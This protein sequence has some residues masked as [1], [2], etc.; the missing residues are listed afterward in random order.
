M[1][2]GL[3]PFKCL[4]VLAFSGVS[5]L[6]GDDLG[7]EVPGIRELSPRRELLFFEQ[8][9]VEAVPKLLGLAD[10]WLWD[11]ESGSITNLHEQTAA[12]LRSPKLKVLRE[13]YIAE[14][15]SLASNEL[16][17]AVSARDY[18]AIAKVALRYRF[19][20]AGDQAVLHVIRR[21]VDRGETEVAALFYRGYLRDQRANLVDSVDKRLMGEAGVRLLEQA[22]FDTEAQDPTALTRASEKLVAAWRE[23]P[24]TEFRP[25]KALSELLRL[26]LVYGVA[27]SEVDALFAQCR[28]FQPLAMIAPEFKIQIELDAFQTGNF[29]SPIQSEWIERF[30]HTVQVVTSRYAEIIIRGDSTEKYSALVRLVAFGE[31]AEPM[32]PVLIVALDDSDQKVWRL[33]LTLIGRLGERGKSASG[34]M[35]Q[36]LSDPRNEF[37][38]KSA[39]TL[40][41][42][43]NAAVPDLAKALLSEPLDQRLMIVDLLIINGRTSVT[44]LPEI[45]QALSDS[46]PIMQIAALEILSVLGEASLPALDRV[47]ALTL[48]PDVSVEVA[49]ITAIRF[50]GPKAS[51]AID[52][53]KEKLQSKSSKVRLAAV[54]ALGAMG[55]AASSAAERLTEVVA[56][57]P[58]P[59]VREQATEALVQVTAF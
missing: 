57:D 6:F 39:Y 33:A 3:I 28:E 36:G 26:A 9:D 47:S 37:R 58:S 43:G 20:P 1:K 44:A 24:A 31:T 11:K 42:M 35:I 15:R 7:L 27:S 54:E 59:E 18:T 53:L 4:V 41:G 8:H 55:K 14:F 38:L 2:T 40:Q 52:P 19:T 17:D 23:T 45:I 25:S 13:N 48:D 29:T 32:L 21:S 56:E 10:P 22:G 46:N 16:D 5:P 30:P 51:P 12:K 34:R 50:M 49:A